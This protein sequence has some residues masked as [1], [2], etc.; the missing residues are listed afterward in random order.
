[1]GVL[2]GVRV[3]HV[4]VGV[5]VFHGGRVLVGVQVGVRVPVEVGVDVE[6]AVILRTCI[7]ATG[8]PPS[9][10]SA[11]SEKCKRLSPCPTLMYDTRRESSPLPEA[12]VFSANK[13]TSKA[14]IRRAFSC[15]D[16][17]HLDIMQTHTTYAVAP[18]RS[19]TFALLH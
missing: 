4:G 2:V 8:G 10:M 9:K 6:V 12:D 5:G 3:S 18:S 16:A 7:A 15:G 1:M 11:W 19:M 13:I 14:T 17:D